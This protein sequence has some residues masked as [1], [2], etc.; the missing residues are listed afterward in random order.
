MLNRGSYTFVVWSRQLCSF[1]MKAERDA[2]CG[3]KCMTHRTMWVFSQLLWIMPLGIRM[4]IRS[5]PS[6][7]PPS[8]TWKTCLCHWGTETEPWKQVHR[9]PIFLISSAMASRCL[10]FTSASCP[11]DSCSEF[12]MWSH[13]HCLSWSLPPPR[14]VSWSLFWT[15]A[16]E[17]QRWGLVPGLQL[18]SGSARTGCCALTR[19]E[20]W[21]SRCLGAQCSVREQRQVLAIGSSGSFSR[22][23]PWETGIDLNIH[24]LP[25][26]PHG[27]D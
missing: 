18:G 15:G 16:N 3:C 21:Q 14:A 20:P 2:L 17:A 19:T 12:H 27:E 8:S 11:C 6:A 10:S 24:V 4:L 1:D 25:H 23:C 13:G 7:I 5:D 26:P 9:D 22:T